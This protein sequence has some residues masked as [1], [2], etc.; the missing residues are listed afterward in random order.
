MI[1]FAARPVR[2]SV[3]THHQEAKSLFFF[4]DGETPQAGLFAAVSFGG[5][6]LHL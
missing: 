4:A 3:A 1:S 5:T 2:G 6:S